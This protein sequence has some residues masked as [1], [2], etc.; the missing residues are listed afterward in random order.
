VAGSPNPYK[1]KR[2]KVTLAYPYEDDAGKV[3]EPDTTVEVADV[4]GKRL[5]AEGF[6][7][8]PEPRVST[9]KNK[10]N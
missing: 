6:A 1:E 7:R 3:Q 2:M 8:L 5:V 4:V 10:E 9:S